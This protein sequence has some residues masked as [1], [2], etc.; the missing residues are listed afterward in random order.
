MSEFPEFERRVA[1]LIADPPV[2]P[3]P[4]SG[5]PANGGDVFESNPAVA[6]IKAIRGRR[7]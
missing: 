4:V 5:T 3:T 2:A 7:P 1:R 6:L